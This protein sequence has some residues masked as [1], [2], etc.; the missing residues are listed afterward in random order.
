MNTLIKILRKEALL[1]INFVVHPPF[2]SI[3]NLDDESKEKIKE[4]VKN[5]FLDDDIIGIG[6]KYTHIIYHLEQECTHGLNPFK[7][8]INTLDKQRNPKYFR[9]PTEYKRLFGK[10]L[11]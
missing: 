9:L 4:K 10:K 11:I 2:L 3:N 7:I 6:T 8:F 5:S 1:G